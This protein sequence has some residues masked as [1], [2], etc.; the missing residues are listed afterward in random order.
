MVTK[1]SL[2]ENSL[3][4]LTKLT[5]ELL[6]DPLVKGKKSKFHGRVAEI[7]SCSIGALLYFKG[8]VDP[9]VVEVSSDEHR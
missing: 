4:N 6:Q 7:H 5:G 2:V 8:M 3:R 1:E 9:L